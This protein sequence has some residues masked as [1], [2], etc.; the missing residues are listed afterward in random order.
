MPSSKPPRAPESAITRLFA[1]TSTLSERCLTLP[2]CDA[3]IHV[4]IDQVEPKCSTNPNCRR[5]VTE[6]LT[7]AKNRRAV[8]TYETGY[9]CLAN[10]NQRA[11]FAARY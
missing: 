6:L 10:V 2:P 4:R 9:F 8:N 1:P 11:I 7:P 5:K 3:T